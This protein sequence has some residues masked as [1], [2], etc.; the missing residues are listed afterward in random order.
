MREPTAG[1]KKLASILGATEGDEESIKAQIAALDKGHG[2]A[3]A[4]ELKTE[5]AEK[6][7]EKPAEESSNTQT[8]N[9]VH[10]KSMNSSQMKTYNQMCDNIKK[11]SKTLDASL[12]MKALEKRESLNTEGVDSSDMPF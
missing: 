9:E 12:Y 6:E 1:E 11:F 3:S 4:D 2:N 10:L 7:A 5:T 8:E